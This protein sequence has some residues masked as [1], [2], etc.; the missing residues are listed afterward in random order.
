MVNVSIYTIH[1]SYG[2]CFFG[3]RKKS[4]FV[5]F[6]F[7][8]PLLKPSMN[9]FPP[10]YFDR[11]DSRWLW[12]KYIVLVVSGTHPTWIPLGKPWIGSLISLVYLK[13]LSETGMDQYLL[14][15][16]GWTLIIIQIWCHHGFIVA[17]ACFK[18]Y[19]G[20]PWCYLS[21]LVSGPHNL[22]IIYNPTVR[23][24][25]NWWQNP[26][27]GGDITQLLYHQFDT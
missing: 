21:G 4:V 1:G 24:E 23:G 3:H 2:I 6:V 20:G 18:P 14:H 25:K 13:F 16:G 8:W 17:L 26:L 7:E 15:L 12:L 10:E 5:C 9:I 19:L 22:S 11:S 27:L